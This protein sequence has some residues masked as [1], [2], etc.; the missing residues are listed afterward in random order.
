MKIPRSWQDPE[1]WVLA[2]KDKACRVP[3]SAGS[4]CHFLQ[5]HD[6]RHP[7]HLCC[8]RYMS[9]TPSSAPTQLCPS[10]PVCVSSALAVCDFQALEHQFTLRAGNPRR[11]RLCKGC[12]SPRQHLYMDLF[13]TGQLLV[14]RSSSRTR[15]LSHSLHSP[16]SPCDMSSPS[17]TQCPSR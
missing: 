7:K 3:A 15:R 16:D 11:C 14:G 9:S 2:W 17:C 6:S 1:G 8:S 12:P 10:F 4:G 13:I 5:P